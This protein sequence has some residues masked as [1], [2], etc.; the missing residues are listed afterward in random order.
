MIHEFDNALPKIKDRV[1]YWTGLK[2]NSHAEAKLKEAIRQ[3][4]DA[5][6]L[7]EGQFSIYLQKIIDLRQDN[8]E[9]VVK[10]TEL[11]V[12]PETYFFR[13]KGQFKLLQE[14][15]LPKI[16]KKRSRSKTLKLWSAGCST[17]EEAYSLAI[18]VM[19]LIPD[20][21]EWKITIIGSDIHQSAIERAQKGVF[22]A[23]SF[24]SL[25]PYIFQTFFRSIAPTCWEI[26][27]KIV[28]LVSFCKQNL[29]TDSFPSVRGQFFAMDL[30][31][32][33][34]VFIYFHH[35]AILTVIKKILDT[36]CN[37][38]VLLTG[39]GEL[40]GVHLPMLEELF[41]KESVVYQKRLPGPFDGPDL[42]SDRPK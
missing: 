40:Q 42:M 17:G 37:G 2:F 29:V 33:R 20:W 7:S 32:C 12:N 18:L 28:N 19:L 23:S 4:M 1:S 5:L 21:S 30:V 14:H 13:D 8:E 34:N 6:S 24:R 31:L 15:I 16:I 22:Y 3:R 39:H 25:N 26:E 27:P 11:L 38:G 41:L 35:N 10:L 9:E 36:L